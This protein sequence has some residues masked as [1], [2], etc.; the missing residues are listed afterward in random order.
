MQP[1]TWTY[2][3]VSPALAASDG[4]ATSWMFIKSFDGLVSPEPVLKYVDARRMD[5]NVVLKATSGSFVH[6]PAESPAVPQP[7]VISHEKTPGWTWPVDSEP[8]SSRRRKREVPLD[9]TA[10]SSR[11]KRELPLENEPPE[12]EFDRSVA[13]SQPL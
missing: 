3:A 1:M 4:P 6:L 12:T 5:I 2:R 10:S 8:S 11:R 9:S 7:G 13:G